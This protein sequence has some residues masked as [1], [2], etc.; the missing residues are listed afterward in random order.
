M[1]NTTAKQLKKTAGSAIFMALG[2]VLPFITGQIPEIGNMLCPMHIPV[3]LCGMLFG[4]FYGAAVGLITP[5]LRSLMFSAPVMYPGAVSMAFE[6][7]AYGAIAGLMIR[8]LPR[9]IPCIYVSLLTAMVG[10]RVVWAAVRMLLTVFGGVPFTFAVFIAEG[11]VNAVPGLILQIAVIPPIV[12]ALK[13][14][15]LMMD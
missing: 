1:K 8:L 15:D 14:A 2:V 9:N 13:R 5:L 3:L 11:F 10:G 6:L 12:L 4:P 7:L